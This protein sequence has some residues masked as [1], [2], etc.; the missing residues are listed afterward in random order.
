MALTMNDVL[1]PGQNRESDPQFK[2]APEG[3]HKADAE[4]LAA[5][6][7]I[8]LSEDHW[9][10]IR[11]L[12]ACFAEDQSPPR[13]RL[14]DALEARFGAAGGLSYLHQKFPGGPITQGCQL[15]GLHPPAG[16]KDPSFGTVA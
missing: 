12:Q 16:S 7:G 14:R 2:D 5:Q 1:H 10:T 11:I 4:K 15:A 9:E 8:T 13:R 6:S 3:W